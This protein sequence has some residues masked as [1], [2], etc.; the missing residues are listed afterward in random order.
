MMMRLNYF[1][2]SRTGMRKFQFCRQIVFRLPDCNYNYT[3]TTAEVQH[4]PNL[5][6]VSK[7]KR[8]PNL[9][10]LICTNNNIKALDYFGTFSRLRVLDLSFNKICSLEGLDQLSSLRELNLQNNAISSVEPI[11]KL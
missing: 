4:N 5:N 6:D 2:I 9:Q 11:T 8:F 7:L 1:H 10:E 3:V